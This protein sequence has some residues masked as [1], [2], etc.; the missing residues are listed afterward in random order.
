MNL[1]VQSNSFLVYC[2]CDPTTA[3]YSEA[4]VPQL[5]V[6]INQLSWKRFQGG[7]LKVSTTSI[8]ERS[9]YCIVFLYLFEYPLNKLLP[10]IHLV[11]DVKVWDIVEELVKITVRSPFPA[12][13]FKID[14]TKVDNL[15]QLERALMAG[16]LAAF[17]K[18]VYL[19]NP[20]YA[21]Y[22]KYIRFKS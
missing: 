6:K 3:I 16:A 4:T 13:P 5:R 11:L 9:S 20:S 2:S 22:C 19:K 8:R 21:D 10:S 15:P 12:N 1:I 14:F 17:L 7:K 18:K